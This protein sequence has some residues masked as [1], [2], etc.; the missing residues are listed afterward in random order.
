MQTFETTPANTPCYETTPTNYKHHTKEEPSPC[1]LVEDV[2]WRQSLDLHDAGE[3]F[4]LVLPGEEGVA[5]EQL[6]KDAAQTPHVNWHGV[7]QPKN[8]LGRTVEPTLDVGV[9]CEH[10]DS[11]V[12]LTDLLSQPFLS[13]LVPPSTSS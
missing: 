12:T 13:C 4:N 5:C 11:L 8:H 2:L 3:L 10:R 6:G 1:G 9:H 7:G